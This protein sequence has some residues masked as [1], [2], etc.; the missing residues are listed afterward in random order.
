[1]SAAPSPVKPHRL[2]APSPRAPRSN[3]FLQPPSSIGNTLS[4]DISALLRP[5]PPAPR[6]GDPPP[7]SNQQ[8]FKTV[9]VPTI[10]RSDIGTIPA[11]HINKWDPPAVR[12]SG[13]SLV[14]L[15]SMAVLSVVLALA[16]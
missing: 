7:P 8:D 2:L 16:S 14:P 15:L 11:F 1:M 10:R 5:S 13:S 4:L 6:K 12:A 9:R 3:P